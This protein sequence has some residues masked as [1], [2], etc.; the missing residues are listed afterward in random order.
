[1]SFSWLSDLLRSPYF[2]SCF[3]KILPSFFFKIPPTWPCSRPSSQLMDRRPVAH[4]TLPGGAWHAEGAQH[5][6]READVWN[7]TLLEIP[8]ASDRR[9]W[10]VSSFSPHCLLRRSLSFTLV[11]LGT[12]AHP[13]CRGLRPL[14]F[15]PGHSSCSPLREVGGWPALSQV[16]SLAARLL[17]FHIYFTN[18]YV[19]LTMWQALF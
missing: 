14:C 9:Q 13:C 6:Q 19:T 15:Q 2:L 18:I 10:A 1:M 5:S 8:R 11:K 17:W 12:A 16:G 3:F 4:S 7:R